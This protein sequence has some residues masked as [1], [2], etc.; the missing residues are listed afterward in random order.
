[1]KIIQ[2]VNAE[3]LDGPKDFLPSST[4][5]PGHSQKY[6]PR[7]HACHDFLHLRGIMDPDSRNDCSP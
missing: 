6:V 2:D 3:R 4:G 7:L 5:E 1:M